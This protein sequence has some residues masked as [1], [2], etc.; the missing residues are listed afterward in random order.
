M[1]RCISLATLGL[2]TTYPNPLVGSIVVHDGEIIGEGWH[3]K[4]GEAHAEVN[5]INSVADKN[6]LSNAT[7]YVSLEPCS[8]FGKT[9]PC[10]DLII[11][12]KIP[13]V[14]VGSLDPNPLVAGK[15]IEKLENAG[16]EV[17]SGILEKDCDWLNRRFF[18]IFKKKRPYV[19]L[20]WA[21]TT[22][23]FIAPDKKDKQ[24]PVWITGLASRQLVHKW[25]SEEQAILAGTQTV[26]SDNPSL[27]TRLWPGNSPLRIVLDTNAR[28]AEDLRVFDDTV[29]TMII[30]KRL[31]K[32]NK[33]NTRFITVEG[34]MPIEFLMGLLATTAVQSVIIEGGANT[35]SRFIAADIW[36]EA[37][38]F[39]GPE[40][41]GNGISA[42]EL[43]LEPSETR[44]LGK[45]QL[46][47]FYNP[48]QL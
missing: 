20:K 9:P 27:T 46:E 3:R 18:T 17:I 16:I 2:G 7:I 5:A 19:I 29:P 35:L 14:I 15:G 28:L 21:Q 40:K 31:D 47:I 6:L 44:Q 33:K 37:R 23:A 11:K 25:R 38:V 8:H 22:D 10:A 41:F 30:G 42:P 12:H 39:T 26:Q 45:D 1:Q 24:E 4:A 43:K 34:D 36:D 48:E 32:G 13:R